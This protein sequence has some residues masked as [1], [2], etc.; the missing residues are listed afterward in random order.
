[1]QALV[2]LKSIDITSGCCHNGFQTAQWKNVKEITLSQSGLQ[3][4]LNKYA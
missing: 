1:M 3:K 4:L 2:K